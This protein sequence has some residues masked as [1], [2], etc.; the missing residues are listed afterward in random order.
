MCT[1]P[2]TVTVKRKNFVGVHMDGQLILQSRGFM[3]LRN[4]PTKGT[5][6][7]DVP[8]GSCS[9]CLR[10][11]RRTLEMRFYRESLVRPIMYFVTL[12]YRQ[13]KLPV[14]YMHVVVD[15]DS[16]CEYVL[17]RPTTVAP[18]FNKTTISIKIDDLRF[19]LLR[20]LKT[21]RNPTGKSYY[22]RLEYETD[23]FEHR[24]RMLPSLHRKDVRLWLKRSRVRYE[25]E[26][27][28]KM[29]DF[30]YYI[31]G[32]HGYNTDRPHYH[33]CFFG[34]KQ[35]ELDYMLKSW[36][37][38]FGF[39]TSKKVNSLNPDKSNGFLL[40]G[41]YVAKY[42]S[43]G[44]CESSC[45]KSGQVEKPR[46]MSSR[47]FGLGPVDGFLRDYYLGTRFFGRYDPET[48]K[49][50]DGTPLSH[51]QIQYLAEYVASHLYFSI[52]SNDDSIYNYPMHGALRRKIFGIYGIEIDKKTPVFRG[53][54]AIYLL[55]MDVA[56]SRYLA[57]CEREYPQ[58]EA[59][60]TSA[61]Y[62]R[63]VA[64]YYANQAAIVLAKETA[65]KEADQ[66]SFLKSKV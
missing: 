57:K 43:K 29:S 21:Y 20:D 23:G 9:E 13:P 48:L 36:A 5:L 44:D 46:I 14:S 59:Y 65:F 55:A 25:R 53:F 2:R 51:D 45:V 41:K 8:C 15:K 66:L 42:M 16:G 62:D 38:D 60:A 12:T 30:T 19:S 40:V 1:R 64:A 35:H 31:I 6:V 39:F 18:R 33:A 26:F 50:A 52:A 27:G 32:E 37:E 34:I 54:N 24:T 10:K 58:P 49:L 56:R 7:I 17:G 63:A 11:K 3:R 28:R 22:E 47:S 4:D 61:D